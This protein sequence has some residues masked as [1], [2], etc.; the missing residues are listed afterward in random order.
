LLLARRL[1]FVEGAESVDLKV[2]S[3]V[4]MQAVAEAVVEK[5]RAVE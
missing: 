3:G 4:Q 5:P 2:E 1:K